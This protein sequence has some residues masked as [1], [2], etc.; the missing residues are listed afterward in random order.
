[1]THPYPTVRLEI[2]GRGT[3]AR[4]WRFARGNG[5]Q[6][7]GPGA[8]VAVPFL[9]SSVL[10]PLMQ[11]GRAIVF[12]VAAPI[13]NNQRAGAIW[14]ELRLRVVPNYLWPKVDQR[15]VLRPRLKFPQRPQMYRDRR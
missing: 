2:A 13:R 11:S 1:M 15:P 14:S 6:W 9:G 8:G 4:G 7:T 3:G 5:T 10:H 12:Q